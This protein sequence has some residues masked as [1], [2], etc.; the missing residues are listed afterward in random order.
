MGLPQLTTTRRT[1][2][3]GICAAAD[4]AAAISAT[5]AAA[6]AISVATSATSIGAATLIV[7]ASFEDCG[8]LLLRAESQAL[9]E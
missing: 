9:L 3:W 5:A 4:A 1:L 8:E 2:R 7:V 6:A